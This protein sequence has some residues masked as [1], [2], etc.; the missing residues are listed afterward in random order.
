MNP[1]IFSIIIPCFNSSQTIKR[2]IDSVINQVNL[3]NDFFN[4]SIEIIIVDDVSDDVED[5]EKNK[6]LQIK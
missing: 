2:A 4:E 3:K 1:L 5:L 6:K